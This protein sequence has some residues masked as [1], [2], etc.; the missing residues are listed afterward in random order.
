MKRLLQVSVIL[1]LFFLPLS[2][3]SDMRSYVWTYE[4]MIM[5]PGRAE[6][7]HYLTVSSQNLKSIKGQSSIEHKLEVEVGMTKHFD[8]SIYQKFVQLPEK[9]FQYTGFDLRARFLIGEKN[10]FLLDPLIYVEY[11]SNA[12]FSAHKLETKLILAKDIGRFNFVFNPI[13]EIEYEDETEFV[14]EYAFATRYEF[15]K[16]F[17][18]G[19]EFK[20]DKDVHYIGFVFSHGKENLWIAA[21]PTFMFSKNLN[22]K[23]EFQFR[24]IL[25]LG[26]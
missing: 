24:M 4:Y 13:L 21:A 10:Q 7:E 3:Y 25:G 9:S 26:L 20:G 8:F 14:F 16:L 19:V 18:A 17:R 23:P 6:I 22:S 11:G 5:E 12:T 2:S 15:S 1:V